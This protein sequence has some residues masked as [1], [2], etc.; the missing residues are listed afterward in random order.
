MTATHFEDRVLDAVHD[1]EVAAVDAGRDIA[2]HV[3][4]MVPA[5]AT[6]VTKMTDATFDFAGRML[7][8]QLETAHRLFDRVREAEVSPRTS[9]KSSGGSQKTSAAR[10]A[11]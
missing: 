9:R 3:N 2:H 1:V 8:L 5:M 10:K 4:D 7:E 11:A 6:D